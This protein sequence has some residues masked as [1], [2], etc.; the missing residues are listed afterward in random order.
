[1]PGAF[2]GDV[3]E[4]QNAP[5]ADDEDEDSEDDQ[6]AP[7]LP[8]RIARGFMNMIWGGN[9]EVDDSDSEDEP[10]NPEADDDVD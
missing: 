3:I 1:M 4:E 7:I 2:A 5:H 10:A 6:P 9:A 8:I